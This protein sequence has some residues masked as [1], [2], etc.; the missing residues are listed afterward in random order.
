MLQLCGLSL[1]YL[2]PTC[3]FTTFE[4]VILEES[5]FILSLAGDTEEIIWALA[6]RIMYSVH[7]S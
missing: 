7:L 5:E 3:N 4:L 2:E 6:I 1:D